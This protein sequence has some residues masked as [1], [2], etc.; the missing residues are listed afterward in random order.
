MAGGAA[1]ST[2]TFAESMELVEERFRAGL[3]RM[4]RRHY[5]GFE[6]AV[7]QR[8]RNAYN[9]LTD[10]VNKFASDRGAMGMLTRSMISFRRG[11]FQGLMVALEREAGPGGSFERLRDRVDEL[12]PGVG[13][14]LANAFGSLK[15][16]IS[17]AAPW[18]DMFGE[19]MFEIAG[20]ALPAA[21]GLSAMGVNF[22]KI[23]GALMGMARSLG[24]FMLL[25]GLGAGIYYLSRNLDEVQESLSNATRQFRDFGKFVARIA[26]M[27]D[28]QQLGTDI[29]DG[30]LGAFESL[31]G[32]GE[33]RQMTETAQNIADGFR[34]LFEGVTQIVGGL[35]RGMWTRIVEWI[36]EPPDVESQV[37]R[38]GA[39]LGVTVGGT[40]GTAMFTP[41]RQNVIN[42]IGRVFSNM[43]SF[44]TGGRT[45]A[46]GALR[47]ILRRLPYIGAVIGVLFD[48]PDIIASFKTEGI[49]SGFRTLFGS[50][51]NGLLFGIPRMVEGA[52]GGVNITGGIFDFLMDLFNI[53]EIVAYFRSGEILRGIVEALY[54]M[55][56]GNLVRMLMEHVLGEDAVSEYLDGVT[57]LLRTWGG[58]IQ[59]TFNQW[60]SY[61]EPLWDEWM[62]VF[63]EVGGV[64]GELWDDTLKPLLED[65]LGFDLDAGG[66]GDMF[67]D[68]EGSSR[69]FGET[70]RGVMDWLMPKIQ[71]LSREAMPLVV[72]WFQE[73]ADKVRTAVRVLRAVGD[74]FEFLGGYISWWWSNVTLP[75]FNALRE[76]G[77]AVFGA[78]AEFVSWWWENVT[79]PVFNALSSVWTTV[80]EGIEDAA[81]AV[82][83]FVSNFIT[84]RIDEAALAFR[85]LG[86]AWEATKTVLATGFRLV[87]AELDRYIVVPF[88]RVR[89]TMSTLAETMTVAFLRVKQ[90]IVGLFKTMLEHIQSFFR[91]LPARL[92]EPLANALEAPLENVRESVTDINTEITAVKRRGTEFRRENEQTIRATEARSEEARAAMA[93]A[94]AAQRTAAQRAAM[95]DA[96]RRAA[97]RAGERAMAEAS[98][99]PTRAAVAPAAAPS[100]TGAPPMAVP[101]APSTE[102]AETAARQT[103]TRREGALREEGRREAREIAEEMMISGFSDAAQRQLAAAMRSARSGQREQ[104]VVRTRTRGTPPQTEQEY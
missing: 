76:V 11:G 82:F 79:L 18:L 24:P 80:T 50:I 3:D 91:A 61:V 65:I 35:A 83:N 46:G 7:I 63:R 5:P 81:K 71:W 84:R 10:T 103:A 42:S 55:P 4:A 89:N 37:R 102:Q 47:T 29:V 99:A 104:Q 88:L 74:V 56:G 100:A 95:E 49:L 70:L 20:Q 53:E 85:V 40:L 19:G 13:T 15:D 39:A 93:A 8:Q 32:I 72:R 14:E 45:L 58:I 2:R 75:V 87:A 64:M 98:R 17:A 78:L 101:S 60:L 97:I 62:V 51:V 92:G 48:L 33:G 1:G 16:R 96:Q 59:K 52:L 23:N 77:G 26:G 90:S 12:V 28:W 94:Q 69:S 67:G 6:R 22:R 68:A 66:I 36:M 54:S 44:L 25:I 9:M 27:I 21:T 38:A 31:S 86:A 73:W 43:G 34:S 30:I 57:D 41:L